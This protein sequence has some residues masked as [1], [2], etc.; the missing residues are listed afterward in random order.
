MNKPE[1]LPTE[2]LPTEP[3]ST[4]ALMLALG[5]RARAAAQ[6]LATA[7]DKVK[8]EALRDRKSVV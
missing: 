7:S 2:R 4:A 6:V 5:R 3:D 1:R 8:S